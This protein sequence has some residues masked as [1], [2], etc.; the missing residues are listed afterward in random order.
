MI[1]KEIVIPQRQ[2][3]TIR[4]IDRSLWSGRALPRKQ[5]VA[6][7]L[8]KGHGHNRRSDLIAVLPEREEGGATAS[9]DVAPA[10]INCIWS[11]EVIRVPL[12]IL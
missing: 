3:E 8:G 2:L 10:S 1:P 12:P 7:V 4:Y 11:V 6:V 9:K 5:P